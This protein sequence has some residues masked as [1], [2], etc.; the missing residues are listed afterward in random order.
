MKGLRCVNDPQ[1]AGRRPDGFKQELFSCYG[2]DNIT[3]Q[4]QEGTFFPEGEGVPFIFSEGY[5][6]KRLF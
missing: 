2:I 3:D 1:E 6:V 4:Y 5:G